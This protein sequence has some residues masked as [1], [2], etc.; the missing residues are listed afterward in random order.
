[1][2]LS[3]NTSPE[4]NSLVRTENVEGEISVRVTTLDHLMEE[5]PSLEVSCIKIDVEGADFDVLLGGEKLLD[6]DQPLVFAELWPGRNVLAFAKKLGFSCFAFAKRKGERYSS[7]PATFIKIEAKPI[8]YSIKMI[9]LV[10]QRLLSQFEQ[11][12]EFSV[13]E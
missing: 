9:F 12:A 6:R 11:R 4:M 8:H 2:Q 1:M 5:H 13:T 3:L 10:P 7:K